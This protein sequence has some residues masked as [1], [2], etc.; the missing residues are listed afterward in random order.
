M[1]QAAE[2]LLHDVLLKY[3][4]AACDTPQMLETLA[5]QVWPGV[6]RRKSMC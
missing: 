4:S 3:G 2:Q 5:P 1:N 6:F